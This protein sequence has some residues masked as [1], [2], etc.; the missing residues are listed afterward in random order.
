MRPVVLSLPAEL[1][2]DRGDDGRARSVGQS[3]HAAS[4]ADKNVAGAGSCVPPTQSTFCFAPSAIK[5]RREHSSSAPATSKTCPRRSRSTRGA[6]T[7]P[8]SLASGPTAVWPSNCASRSTSTTSSNRTTGRSNGSRGRF[9]DSRLSMREH[10][11]RRHRAH[12]HDSQGPTRR[13]QR[14]SLVAGHCSTP[15]LFD[16]DRPRGFVRLHRTIAREPVFDHSQLTSPAEG[17]TIKVFPES[18][19]RT[20]VAP[21]VSP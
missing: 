20:Q 13:H 1:S 8:P 2:Q 4:R 3:L 6:P 14:P 9:S 12:A 7:R 15:W 18:L 19:V 10:P 5:R 17:Q 21:A 16:R 11:D